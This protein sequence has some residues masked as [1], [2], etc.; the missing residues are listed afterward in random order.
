MLEYSEMPPVSSLYHE[1]FLISE[2]T[3]VG[4]NPS[5]ADGKLPVQPVHDKDLQKTRTRDGEVA[6][7]PPD[8]TSPGRERPK[9]GPSRFNNPDP[10]LPGLQIKLSHDYHVKVIIQGARGN[11]WMGP[12][13]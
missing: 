8:E 6:P 10:I 9:L 4:E 13:A 1:A 12:T 7:P 11:Q 3:H 5:S 2:D